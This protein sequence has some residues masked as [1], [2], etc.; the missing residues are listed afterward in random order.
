[1]DIVLFTVLIAVAIS[2]VGLLV[3][4]RDRIARTA[5]WLP[6]LVFCGGIIA[7]SVL[8][9]ADELAELAGAVDLA[10]E[11]ELAAGSALVMALAGLLHFATVYPRRVEAVW[12]RWVLLAM[13]ALAFVYVL[14]APIRVAAD[15]AGHLRLDSGVVDAAIGNTFYFAMLLPIGW[16]TFLAFRGRNEN[17]RKA[18]RSLALATGPPVG[19]G[20]VPMMFGIPVETDRLAAVLFGLWLIGIAVSFA[21]GGLPI[22]LE[23]SMRRVLD[24]SADAIFVI[25]TDTTI[26]E[27]NKAALAFLGLPPSVIGQPFE[28]VLRP[29]FKDPAAWSRVSRQVGDAIL[30][31][32][33]RVEGDAGAVG[34]QGRPC[35]VLVDPLRAEGAPGRA[36]GVV[37]RIRDITAEEAAEDA[38]RRARDLQDLVIR[39]MGHDLKTPIAVMTGYLELAQMVLAQPLT[40]AERAALKGH[41]EKAGQATSLMRVI[42]ANARAISRITMGEAAQAPK[43]PADL[44]RMLDEVVGILRPLAQAKQISVKVERPEGVRVPLIPGFESVISNLLSNAIKYTPPGGEITVHLA[45]LEGAVRLEVADTGPG[46]PKEARARLFRKF[47][48]LS[49]EQSVGSQGLGLSIASAIVGLTGGTISVLDRPD[50]RSGTVFRVDIPAGSPVEPA[51]A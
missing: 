47:E 32:S 29:A 9:L 19:I 4:L 50:G 3:W 46:I 10:I 39:V 40:D 7:L 33:Q 34:P 38:A 43:E 35:R 42:M 11:L 25:D 45:A 1:M 24:S 26:A 44:S 20:F 8:D 31:G 13:Y 28:T 21:R 5:L 49:L 51:P 22:A 12:L 41:L 2:T 16:F 30:E 15:G 17:E 36:D 23:A 18:G 48:R 6:L 37:L 14:L 27:T